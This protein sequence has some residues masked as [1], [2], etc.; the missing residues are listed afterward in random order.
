[1]LRHGFRYNHRMLGSL[2]ESALRLKRGGLCF[3]SH[4]RRLQTPAFAA[5]PRRMTQAK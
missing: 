1:M 4:C 2:K 5:R 3:A